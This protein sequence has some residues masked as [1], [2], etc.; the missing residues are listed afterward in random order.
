LDEFATWCNVNR[1][2]FDAGSDYGMVRE[3]LDADQVIEEYL[4][5]KKRQFDKGL[6]K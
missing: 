6:G 1:K 5:F 3:H 2:D 4:K